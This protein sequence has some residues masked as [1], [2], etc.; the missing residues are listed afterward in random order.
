MY[1]TIL[2]LHSRNTSVYN[3]NFQ[4]FVCFYQE[5]KS[6]YIL[7]PIF[8]QASILTLSPRAIALLTFP[9]PPSFHPPSSLSLQACLCT[10]PVCTSYSVTD[11]I[12]YLPISFS[13][14]QLISWLSKSAAVCKQRRS[15]TQSARLDPRSC[16]RGSD[17]Q[18]AVEEQTYHEYS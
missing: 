8:P 10:R 9:A 17:S 5:N 11:C 2:H 15:Q 6:T 7:Y 16:T 12:N 3:D 4:K 13:D 18:S 1:Y 14:T